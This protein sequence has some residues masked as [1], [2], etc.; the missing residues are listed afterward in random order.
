MRKT[1]V[2]S[3]S[4]ESAREIISAI[5]SRNS[6]YV[7]WACWVKNE[8]SLIVGDKTGHEVKLALSVGQSATNCLGNWS[9]SR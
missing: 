9:P 6:H 8:L 2:F 5:E 4:R 3:G 7:S 1:P